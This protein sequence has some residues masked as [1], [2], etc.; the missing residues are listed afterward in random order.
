M[1]T[2]AILLE[3]SLFS[4]DTFFNSADYAGTALL[5]KLATGNA[6]DRTTLSWCVNAGKV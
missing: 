2:N 1:P 6:V 3:S 4:Y 5:P